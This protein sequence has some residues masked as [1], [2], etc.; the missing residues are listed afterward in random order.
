MCGD[1]S[2]II[3]SSNV[4]RQKHIQHGSLIKI[5]PCTSAR[6]SSTQEFDPDPARKLS[7]HKPLL[8]VQ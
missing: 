2:N 5:L 1:Q 8:C 4:Q 6:L 7:A 3:H